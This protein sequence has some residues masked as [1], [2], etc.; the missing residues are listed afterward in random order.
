MLLLSALGLTYIL[1]QGRILNEIRSFLIKLHPIIKDLFSCAM[2]LGFWS[3]I[4]IGILAQITIPEI[5][6]LGFATSFLGY[7][8]FIIITVIE[9]FYIN[10]IKK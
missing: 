5:I 4:F 7:I 9:D 3:G 10:F 6:I 1:K 2:C 8:S